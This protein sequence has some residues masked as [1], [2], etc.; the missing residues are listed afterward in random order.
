MSAPHHGTPTVTT[1]PDGFCPGDRVWVHRGTSWRPGV[2]LQSSP[3]AATVRYRPAE[4]RGTG[5]D[6]VI[7]SS[8]TARDDHDPLLDR[9]TEL[10]RV[11][12]LEQ[13]A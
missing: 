9:T 12:G 7:A 1:P 2:I 3:E 8:L 10:G 13:T 6:T 5:V 11:A 4:A